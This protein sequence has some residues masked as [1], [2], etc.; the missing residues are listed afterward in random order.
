MGSKAMVIERNDDDDAD[1]DD[2]LGTLAAMMH[3]GT[4][5]ESLASSGSPLQVTNLQ[6]IM[7]YSHLTL[8]WNPLLHHYF[9]FMC[10]T[11]IVVLRIMAM[12]RNHVSPHFIPLSRPFVLRQT[13]MNFL[14][15]KAI[16]I[17]R[18]LD[19]IAPASFKAKLSN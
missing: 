16:I 8:A 14:A 2:E 9:I 7:K 10:W 6:S 5:K 1:D 3:F 4:K 11:S 19:R 15:G 17:R 13:T 18:M 12:L